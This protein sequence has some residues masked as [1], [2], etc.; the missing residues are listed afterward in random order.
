MKRQE[1]SYTVELS[2]LL[3]IVVFV[4]F[5]P[6]YT[7]FSLYGQT[8]EASVC[9]WDAEF[10]AEERVRSLTWVEKRKEELQ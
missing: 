8:K 3:P 7:G 5:A 6:I 9:G 4:L 2:L 1:A 10:C